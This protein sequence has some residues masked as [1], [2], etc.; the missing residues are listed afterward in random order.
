MAVTMSVE[1]IESYLSK[2]VTVTLITL[3]RD[4]TALPTPLWFANRGEVIYVGTMRKTQKVKNLLR[5]PR[6]TAQVE[7]GESY[8]ELRA[9]IVKGRAEIVESEEE[10]AWFAEAMAA[11]YAQQRPRQTALPTATKQHY[12]NPRA[13]IKIVPEKV[14]TWDNSKIR[15]TSAP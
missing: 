14:R 6:V 9:V 5:D 3:N 11:K 8:L 4:G 13:V 12:D 15:T 10:L 2:S 7:S 1:E